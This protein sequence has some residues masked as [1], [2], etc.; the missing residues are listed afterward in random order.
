MNEAL[1][2]SE[3]SNS[4][5]RHVLPRWMCMTEHLTMITYYLVQLKEF[6]S[7]ENGGIAQRYKRQIMPLPITAHCL[8][9]EK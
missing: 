6:M 9:C 4:H 8:V 7:I 1:R 2:I 5:L 3:D